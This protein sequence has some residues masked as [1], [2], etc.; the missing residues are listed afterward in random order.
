M[1]PTS[2]LHLLVLAI[3]G[4]ARPEIFAVARFYAVPVVALRNGDLITAGRDN[5]EPMAATIR[6]INESK[7]NHRTIS[8]GG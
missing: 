5:A 2:L 3:N 6:P 1:K 4:R 8:F 7:L